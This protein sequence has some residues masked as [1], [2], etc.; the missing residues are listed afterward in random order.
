[1][2][3]RKPEIRTKEEAIL[4]ARYELARR[5]LLDYCKLV[6]PGYEAP[7]HVLYMIERLE[8]LERGDITRL[9]ICMPPRHSKSLTASQIFPTY[10]IG[11]GLLK[12]EQRSVLLGSYA[13]NLSKGWGGKAKQT[14]T[15]Y[16]GH[17]WGAT[18][19]PSTKAKDDWKLAEIL[20]PN[21][22]RAK[23][24]YKTLEAGM[25]TAGVGGPF[26]GKGADCLVAGTMI[27]TD[28]GQVPIERLS[29]WDT[30]LTYN[31]TTE[32][33]EW[34]SISAT[35]GISS[36]NVVEI[37]TAKG[38]RLRAT[39]DHR[40]H[41]NR[42][43][44]RAGIIN[45]GDQLTTHGDLDVVASA[46]SIPGNHRVFDIQV[47]G[48][49][50]FFANGILVHNCLI[51]DDPIKGAE[52]AASEV[53]R[54][55]V[56]EWY[57]SDA[58]T[59]LMPGGRVLTIMC[60]TGDTSVLMAD[61]TERPLAEIKVGDVVATYEDGG[62]TSSKILNWANNG[63]DTVYEIRMTSGKVVRANARHPFLLQ[64]EDTTEWVRLRDLKIG[65]AI[66]GVSGQE[67]CAQTQG[68]ADLSEPR[69]SVGNTTTSSGLRSLGLI[70]LGI[71][72]NG[73]ERLVKRRAVKSRSVVRDSV[74]PT[75][76][77]RSGQQDTG[78]PLLIQ[79]LV[80]GL[81]SSIDTASTFLNMI[82]SSS[83][84]EAYALSVENLPTRTKTPGHIGG[85]ISASIIATNQARS[86][87]SSV[88][89]VTSPSAMEGRQNTSNL[90]LVTYEITD[91]VEVGVEDVF[92]I[93]VERTG[94]FIANGVVSHN[95]MWH[96]DDL[97]NRLIRD[98][99]DGGE[100]W[101][102]VRFPAICVDENDILGRKKGEA[103]W[104]ERFPANCPTYK[105]V[106]RRKHVWSSLYQQD[107]RQPDGNLFKADWFRY[108]TI[109]KGEYVYEGIRAVPSR[110][111]LYTTS[112]QAFST[113]THA[114]YTVVAL[115]GFFSDRLW[116]LD[117]HRGQYTSMELVNIYRSLENRFGVKKHWVE[118]G[119]F[120]EGKKKI[121]Y[122]RQKGIM[123][124]MLKPRHGTTK[125]KVARADSA[126]PWFEEGKVLF[127]AK[128]PCRYVLEDELL[129]FPRGP[130]D[131]QVDAV[132]Y[133]V[134]VSP[135]GY[136]GITF[137][138]G[139]SRS[140]EEQEAPMDQTPFGGHM[141]K[142]PEW[143]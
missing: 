20:Y 62:I 87:G 47:E 26:T 31:H 112:D 132:S 105:A 84:R 45:P 52:E 136:S 128:H 139:K 69:D 119:A 140:S 104:P 7:T 70:P 129:S 53:I 94:N 131:D 65:D 71:K 39:T 137:G 88:T 130:N 103:L 5:N 35:R 114:D 76:E 78:P 49:E 14:M 141:P 86:G 89:V 58:F 11:R 32:Q 4:Q 57:S 34:G 83:S 43:Y 9:M 25:A 127:P 79:S 91:I 12:G 106:M 100:Q 68:V 108:Y 64:R 48:N 15:E 93:E 40:I 60:M 90:R 118:K 92:D 101:E 2:N 50:N 133:G 63:P 59:R 13:A 1:M 66:V 38:R 42:G 67:W 30:V 116:L 22:P 138:D 143:F 18:L 135:W 27:T 142:R 77:R 74:S 46:R 126:T 121:D 85:S 113:K 6:Y 122:L 55:K 44:R 125:D 115:W 73:R 95:T 17:V 110:M 120:T 10:F 61:G 23:P 123:L 81:G 134:A 99:G 16:G 97:A 33:L 19:D 28:R 36:S 56:W 124:S 72:V 82:G 107:P 24:L 29:V 98:M 3:L 21:G 80:E 117:M 111:Q 8:A 41:S 54:E 102:I 75:T 51:I 96:L 109:E 37:V